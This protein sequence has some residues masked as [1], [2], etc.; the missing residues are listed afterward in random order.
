MKSS[1]PRPV[2]Y[3]TQSQPTLKVKSKFRERTNRIPSISGGE[4]LGTAARVRTRCDVIDA[5]EC[6]AVQPEIEE[7]KRGATF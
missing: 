3:G 6:V 4:T 2:T 1:V 7:P 5:L